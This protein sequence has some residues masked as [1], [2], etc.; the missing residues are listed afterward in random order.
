MSRTLHICSR[1]ISEQHPAHSYAYSMWSYYLP[2]C[3][4]GQA[5]AFSFL[6]HMERLVTCALSICWHPLQPPTGAVPTPSS[7]W[8]LERGW[9]TSDLEEEITPSL[10]SKWPP[11][12]KGSACSL[13]FCSFCFLVCF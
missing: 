5:L 7:S 8:S 2:P 3:W 6:L 12:I 11:V 4:S 10:F 13:L 9:R 1:N